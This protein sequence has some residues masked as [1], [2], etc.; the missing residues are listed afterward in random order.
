MSAAPITLAVR[1]DVVD[2][3]NKIL[4]CIS[5]NDSS[6]VLLFVG[7]SPSYCFHAMTRA[8]RA[9]FDAHIVPMSGRVFIDPYTIPTPDAL[10]AFRRHHLA[11][12]LVGKKTAYIID[13]SH[14]GQ[15]IVSFRQ[16]LSECAPSIRDVRAICL[17]DPVQKPCVDGMKARFAAH[18]GALTEAHFVFGSTPYLWVDLFNDVYVRLVPR[19]PHWEWTHI[20]SSTWPLTREQK[21]AIAVLKQ[22]GKK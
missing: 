21:A 19:N 10:A 17:L 16:V 12:R 22:P 5:I 6:I 14:S 18:P 8:D 3:K 15:S 4:A 1:R 7:N 2:M 20:R 11:S 13:H 9:R